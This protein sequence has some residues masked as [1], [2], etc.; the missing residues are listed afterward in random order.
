MESDVADSS[1]VNK[2]A[3]Q[4]LAVKKLHN[5]DKDDCK[6]MLKHVVYF[7]Y[8]WR[9]A[10]LENGELERLLLR[11]VDERLRVGELSWSLLAY[12]DPV[13]PSALWKSISESSSSNYWHMT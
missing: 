3:E 1:G 7:L 5:G 11:D 2:A 8:T 13:P 4:I 10:S 6:C 12:V 9:T